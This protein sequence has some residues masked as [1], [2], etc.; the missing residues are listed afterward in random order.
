MKYGLKTKKQKAEMI[1]KKYIAVIALVLGFSCASFA[2]P[3]VI[4]KNGR[5][6]KSYYSPEMGFILDFNMGYTLGFGKLSDYANSTPSPSYSVGVGYAFSKHWKVGLYYQS[7]A[8][9]QDMGP[10]II[11]DGMEGISGHGVHNV[12]FNNVLA[13]GEYCF[14]LSQWF[15]PYVSL[16]LG[17]ASVKMY[18]DIAGTYRFEDS[19]WMFALAPEVGMRGYFDR[20]QTVGYKVNVSYNKYFGDVEIIDGKI[21]S[22]SYLRIGGGIFVKI[23]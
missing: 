3:V 12:D 7:A 18:T 16:A 15:K 5:T 20:N 2:Q 13:S 1:S 9:Q 10:L 6:A 22:P 21:S 17:G 11:T 8:F 23:F 19:K 4:E 14:P